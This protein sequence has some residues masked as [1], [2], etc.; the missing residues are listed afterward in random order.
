[1]QHLGA[2]AAAP[3][4]SVMIPTYLPDYNRHMREF[5]EPN[6]QRVLVGELSAR[7]FLYAWADLIEEA[8]RE[9]QAA[10]S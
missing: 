6:F 2:Y 9:F 10:H 3:K 4:T 8:N 1:M 7:D 5:A